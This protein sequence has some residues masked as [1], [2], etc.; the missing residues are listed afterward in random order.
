MGPDATPADA[1]PADATHVAFAGARRLAVGSLAEVLPVLKRRFD[2][3]RADAPLVLELATG[4]QV[5]FDLRGTLADVLARVAP[6]PRGPG[7][8]RLGVTGR[9]VSLLPGHWTWLEA[10]RGGASAALRR[11]VEAAARVAP[12]ADEARRRRDALAALLTN[13]AGDRPHY[14]EVTRALYQGDLAR[15]ATLVE[16][17]P[18]DI[19]EVVL[20]RVDL[21]AQALGAAR[22]PADVVRALLAQV[23]SDGD[24][25]AIARLVAPRYTV[26]RD[27][28]DPWEGQTLDRKGYAA[29]L[30]HSRDAFPDLRFVVDD[31]L[32]DGERVAVRWTAEGTHAGELPG[33]PATQRRLTFTGHTHYAVAHGQ[34]TGHWQVVDRLGFVGQLR[35]R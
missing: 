33:L 24:T 28:G 20:T 35:D 23:W 3:D 26:H 34:V 31:L 5:D 18:A 12:A 21:C 13:L 19:R 17:W 1:T 7:R 16:R 2:D 25:A 29:R 14:E 27:P 11:L 22:S 32:A 6:P 4:K 10:Q 8:P 15:V 30:A 9:E